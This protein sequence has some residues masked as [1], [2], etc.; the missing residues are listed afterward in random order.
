MKRIKA[1][2]VETLRAWLAILQ[3]ERH[4][5]AVATLAAEHVLQETW[6]MAQ[7]EGQ[8]YA[9]GYVVSDGDPLRGD[10]AVPINKEHQAMMTECL[11]AGPWIPTSLE[12]DL[13]A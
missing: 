3:N 13:V 6:F 1:D 2:K 5:E 12:C 4:Q 10:P 7:I 11:E 9:L 8:W